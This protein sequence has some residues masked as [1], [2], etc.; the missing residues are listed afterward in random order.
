[1]LGNSHYIMR[2]LDLI[3]TDPQSLV[4]HKLSRLVPKEW[5]EWAIW[6]G[7]NQDLVAISRSQFAQDLFAMFILETRFGYDIRA[8]TGTFVE[9][10]AFDGLKH[11][12]SFGF[13]QLG[14]GGIILE[15]DS[16]RAIDCRRNRQCEVVHAAVVGTGEQL[17]GR[18]RRRKQLQRSSPWESPS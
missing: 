12:N 16:H 2:F 6:Y 18:E 10:G 11:S 5:V 13:E 7:R 8:F 3:L 17:W 1:M 15:P 4:R 9:F 14:W